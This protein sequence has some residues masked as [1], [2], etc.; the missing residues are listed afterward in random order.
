VT[1]Y[2]V[3][4]TKTEIMFAPQRWSPRIIGEDSR[5]LYT[6]QKAINDEGQPYEPKEPL[7]A[8]PIGSVIELKMDFT[9]LV[10]AEIGL[11]LML[12]GQ[13]PTEKIYPKLGGVKAHGWGAVDID[14]VTIYRMDKNSYLTYERASLVHEEM[15]SYLNAIETTDLLNKAAWSQVVRYL[16]KL[17]EGDNA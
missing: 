15:G 12:M 4:G 1:T 7:E 10:T 17:P 16:G 13:K 11:L 2:P 8:L 14:D 3:E 9:S 5:K 6:H